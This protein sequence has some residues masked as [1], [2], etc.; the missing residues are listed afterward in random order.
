MNINGEQGLYMRL[1]EKRGI[2]SRQEEQCEQQQA[3]QDAIAM[4]RGGGS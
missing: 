1:G 3:P 4:V 2:T